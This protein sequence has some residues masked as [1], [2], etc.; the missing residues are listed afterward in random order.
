[1][2]IA[3][4]TSESHL[5]QSSSRSR[6]WLGDTLVPSNITPIFDEGNEELQ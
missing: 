3:L 2:R 6:E 4:K 5:T 1:M